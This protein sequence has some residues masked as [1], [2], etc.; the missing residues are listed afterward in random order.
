MGLW[1]GIVLCIWVTVLIPINGGSSSEND[2]ELKVVIA[3]AHEVCYAVRSSVQ[4]TLMSS[5]SESRI[6][7]YFVTA[8]STARSA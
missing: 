4:S 2:T 8:S 5:R 1:M 3:A 6:E 7:Q